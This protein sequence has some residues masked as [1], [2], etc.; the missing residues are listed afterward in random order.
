MKL[1]VKQIMFILMSVLLVLT[2]VMAVIALDRVSDLLNLDG[3][4]NVNNPQNSNPASDAILNSSIPTSKPIITE[5]GHEHEFVKVKTY[6]ATCI[7]S[8]YTLY[9]CSCGKP[10]IRDFKDPYGHNY[11][12]YTVVAATC[13]TDGWTERTCSR[14]SNIE[15]TNIVTASHNFEDWTEVE[16]ADGIS[17]QEQRACYGCATTEIRS[18]DP[19]NTWILRVTELEALYGFAHYQIVVD[20]VDNTNDPVYEI[21]LEDG[22]DATGYDY[23]NGEVVLSYLNNDVP[24]QFIVPSYAKVRTLY[25]DGTVTIEPPTEPVIPDPDPENPENPD[26]ENPDPDVGGEGSDGEDSG[27]DETPSDPTDTETE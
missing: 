21:Y 16:T 24:A 7:S 14:C 9:E 19:A 12:E 11:G 17:A 22:M 10:D 23:I 2:V 4:P 18:L 15:K 25:A 27:G 1:T 3:G 6:S 20:V 5:P 13:T 8:G 26:P